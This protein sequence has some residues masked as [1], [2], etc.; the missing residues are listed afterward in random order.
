M[1]LDTSFQVG[2]SCHRGPGAGTA[3]VLFP[4]AP[5]NLAGERQVE[6]VQLRVEGKY[7]WSLRIPE[8]YQKS[9]RPFQEL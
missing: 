7:T 3:R 6:R 9:N 5:S 2:N 1:V 4:G 8:T